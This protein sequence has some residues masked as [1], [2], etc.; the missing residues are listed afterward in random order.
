MLCANKQG[1]CSSCVQVYFTKAINTRPFLKSCLLS[2][3]CLCQQ[4]K[5]V[6][7]EWAPWALGELLAFRL[8]HL[9]EPIHSP[10]CAVLLPEGPSEGFSHRDFPERETSDLSLPKWGPETRGPRG[11]VKCAESLEAT[12]GRGRGHRP[13]PSLPRSAPPLRTSSVTP[14]QTW[15]GKWAGP[16]CRE[17]PALLCVTQSGAGSPSP[18]P[19]SGWKRQGRVAPNWAP[20]SSLGS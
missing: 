17:D 3:P 18:A 11:L 19:G 9:K 20:L 12:A 2:F 7:A 14:S 5:N 10:D 6:E 1:L 13:H 16:L 4:E 15:G 8:C